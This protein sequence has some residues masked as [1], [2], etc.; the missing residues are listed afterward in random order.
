M[1]EATLS[2]DF[3]VLEQSC[4]RFN[5]TSSHFNSISKIFKKLSTSR[6]SPPSANKAAD[7][8]F[9]TQRRCPQKSKTGVSMAPKN[10]YANQ[11]NFLKKSSLIFGFSY[12]VSGLQNL[13]ENSR[14]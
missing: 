8:G 13:Q 4:P 3:E 12:T 11:K 6:M 2:L 1:I 14:H 5:S 10:A 7:S 9:E